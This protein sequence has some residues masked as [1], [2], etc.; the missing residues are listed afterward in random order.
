LAGAIALRRLELHRHLLVG[1]SCTFTSDNAG[2][3]V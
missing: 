3:V 1:V 2:R